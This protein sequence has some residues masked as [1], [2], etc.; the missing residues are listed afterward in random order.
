MFQ[1]H[2]LNIGQLFRRKASIRELPRT[3]ANSKRSKSQPLIGNG[4]T[5]NDPVLVNL[6]KVT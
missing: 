3:E 5:E 4:T 1:L 6:F 2:G